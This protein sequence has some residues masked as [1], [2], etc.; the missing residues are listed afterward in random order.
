[1]V[2]SLHLFSESCWKRCLNKNENVSLRKKDAWR[3]RKQAPSESG[4]DI[5]DDVSGNVK[6]TAVQLA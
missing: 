3:F 2:T 1:M 4:K 6:R 5:P